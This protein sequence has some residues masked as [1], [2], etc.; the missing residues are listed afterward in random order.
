M[1]NSP[2]YQMPSASPGPMHARQPWWPLAADQPGNLVAQPASCD[3]E[4]AN[5]RADLDEMWH[6]YVGIRKANAKVAQ[7]VSKQAIAHHDQLPPR[8]EYTCG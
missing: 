1:T 4:H 5:R 7:W 3:S 8:G 2:G 6:A